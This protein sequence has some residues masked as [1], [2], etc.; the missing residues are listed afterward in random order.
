MRLDCRQIV[1]RSMLILLFIFVALNAHAAPS[2]SDCG[3]I[4]HG[5]TVVIAGV[6]FGTKTSAAPIRYDDF[7]SSTAGQSIEQA[8]S[9]WVDV[10]SNDIPS[11]VNVITVGTTNQRTGSTKNVRAFGDYTDGMSVA[12]KNTVGFSSTGKALVSLWIRFD[13]GIASPDV[14]GDHQIKTWRLA[15]SIENTGNVIFPHI[16]NFN[17]GES[18]THT[19]YF[20]NSRSSPLSSNTQYFSD[21]YMV[22]DTWHHMMLAVD[23]GTAGSSDGSWYA[24]MNEEGR[25][26]TTISQ[27]NV[28][29]VGAADGTIDAIKLDN[30]IGNCDDAGGTV[31]CADPTEID[32]Y[33]DDI[34]ID[35]S[36]ARVEIGDAATYANCT[37]REIQIPTAWSST[38]I[39]A[40]ANYGSF[41]DGEQ[42]Y[43]FVVDED[44]EASSG[45]GPI[46]LGE[47]TAPRYQ[48]MTFR[49][50]GQ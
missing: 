47:S 33:Y 6:D 43:L 38:E 39:T 23:I 16:A 20:Q 9:W 49:G 25:A 14:N 22:D 40:I 30:Y 3:G 50:M 44:G 46:L 15:N 35:N 48:G 10:D 41:N 31:E 18:G 21:N 4:S 26:Y 28:M 36:W 19:H 13:W 37:H 1:T 42:V 7:E 5:A 12:Y 29:V 2:V 11:R 45:Y 17:H 34:Y 8:T 32:L 27:S 24:W